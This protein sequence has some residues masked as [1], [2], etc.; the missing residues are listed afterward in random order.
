MFLW[1]CMHPIWLQSTFNNSKRPLHQCR[2][3]G[4]E[5]LCLRLNLPLAQFTY[6]VVH[7]VDTLYRPMLDPMAGLVNI[8]RVFM[9][10]ICV[11]NVCPCCLYCVECRCLRNCCRL[12]NSVK[13]A[14]HWN[15][16][17]YVLLKVFL[18]PV[19][20]LTLWYDNMH[21]NLWLCCW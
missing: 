18:Q 7:V 12:S 9:N 11:G 19:G 17:P 16:G 4:M 5:L 6:V 14:L 2:A 8:W 10:Y 15:G 3:S 21:K 13:D 20:L 1:M